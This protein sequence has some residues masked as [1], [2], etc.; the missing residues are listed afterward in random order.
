MVVLSSEHL[1][2]DIS[3]AFL[4]AS[5]ICL[6]GAV[7]TEFIRGRYIHSLDEVTECLRDAVKVC[8][9][10]SHRVLFCTGQDTLHSPLGGSFK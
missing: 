6:S 10:S 3:A 8:P 2:S 7:N 5:F 4:V 9:T 1:T